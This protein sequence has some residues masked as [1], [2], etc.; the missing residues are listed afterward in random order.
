M[1]HI[2]SSSVVWRRLYDEL[3]GTD[4][5]QRFDLGVHAC[6]G[7]TSRLLLVTCKSAICARRAVS[8][9]LLA[10]APAAASCRSRCLCC[11]R[12]SANDLISR[13]ALLRIAA[14]AS[15]SARARVLTCRAGEKSCVCV[16][17]GRAC[18]ASL[19]QAY[20][21]SGP[22]RDSQ[23]MT[24]VQ[25]PGNGMCIFKDG[26]PGLKPWG[27]EGRERVTS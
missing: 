9:L 4:S 23:T 2:A 20:T 26:R 25:K 15:V 22:T 13:S 1:K 24:S 14:A 19:K 3:S 21:D 7:F 6:L 16:S 8:A 12:C 27:G 11:S 5:L 17:R 10:A 18:E